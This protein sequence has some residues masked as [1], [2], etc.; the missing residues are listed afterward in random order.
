MGSETVPLCA[1]PGGEEVPPVFI[2]RS[3]LKASLQ[4]QYTRN[5][6]GT[7]S[8][9]LEQVL[10]ASPCTAARVPSCVRSCSAKLE[11][12]SLPWLIRRVCHCRQCCWVMQCRQV[13]AQPNGKAG[14]QLLQPPGCLMAVFCAANR[15]QPWTRAAARPQSAPGWC[16]HRRAAPWT[17]AARPPRC[18]TTQRTA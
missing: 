17:P 7:L 4:E 5:S 9:V 18:P 16:R 10:S 1:G 12:V 8:L 14:C 3:G 2:D 15:W 13:P 11:P 6:K